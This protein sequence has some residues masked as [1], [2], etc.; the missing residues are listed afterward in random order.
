MSFLSS[1]ATIDAILTKKGRE[2]L[3]NGTFNPTKF[4]LAD[5]CIDYGMLNQEDG[6][7]QILQTKILEA[8]SLGGESQTELR[9]KLIIDQSGL[10]LVPTISVNPS[11]VSLVKD[12]Y[13]MIKAYVKDA[14]GKIVNIDRTQISIELNTNSG[15]CLDPSNYDFLSTR[16]STEITKLNSKLDSAYHYL[17]DNITQHPEVIEH[18]SPMVDADGGFWFYVIRYADTVTANTSI[19]IKNTPAGN[20]TVTANGATANTGTREAM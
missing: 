18:I 3:A 12:G 1:T 13:A 8:S 4:A 14:F 2:K 17:L 20:Y 7:A 19:E 5:D 16:P 15:F 9:Y 6:E 11:S 10:V